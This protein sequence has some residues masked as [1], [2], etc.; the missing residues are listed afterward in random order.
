MARFISEELSHQVVTSVLTNLLK[1]HLQI[2]FLR[3]VSEKENLSFV[4]VDHGIV[5]VSIVVAVLGPDKELLTI[6]LVKVGIFAR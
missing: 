4:G 2:A 1:D 6:D 3:A 5:T